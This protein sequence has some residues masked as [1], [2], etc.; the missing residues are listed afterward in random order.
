MKRVSNL[1][2]QTFQTYLFN[3]ETKKGKEKE[4]KKKDFETRSKYIQLP[5]FHNSMCLVKE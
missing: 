3:G 2:N 4:R 5:I 1:F